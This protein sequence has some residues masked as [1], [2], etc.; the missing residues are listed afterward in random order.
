MMAT[1]AS[2]VIA[3]LAAVVFLSWAQFVVIATAQEFGRVGIKEC[4]RGLFTGI[5]Y[6]PWIS[7]GLPLLLL[8]DKNGWENG[9]LM[10]LAALMCVIA[11]FWVTRVWI[12]I[13]LV[14]AASVAWSCWIWSV[15]LLLGSA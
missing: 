2:R 8:F 12:W 6:F 3:A 10:A 15:C 9:V 1:S 14:I 11:C 7:I 5:I 13:A 4:L